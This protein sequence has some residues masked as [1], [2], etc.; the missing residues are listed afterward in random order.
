MSFDQV[1]GM[2]SNIKA[3]WNSSASLAEWRQSLR[4]IPLVIVFLLCNS[5]TLALPIVLSAWAP[6]STAPSGVD[7]AMQAA[8]VW[9]LIAAGAL[10]PPLETLFWTVC[11]IEASNILLR[12]PV[13]GVALSVFAYSVVYHFSGSHLA[14]IAA[15]WLALIANVSYLWLRGRSKLLAFTWATGLR[16]VFVGFALLAYR[17]LI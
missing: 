15:A 1:E 17:G 13:W 2:R 16:W 8:P 6:V 12:R 14:M 5:A 11:F 3:L 10:V 4:R 7:T 9:M